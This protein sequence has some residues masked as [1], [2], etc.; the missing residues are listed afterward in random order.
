MKVKI[1]STWAWHE[2]GSQFEVDIKVKELGRKRDMWALHANSL[3]FPF[4]TMDACHMIAAVTREWKCPSQCPKYDRANVFLIDPRPWFFWFLGCPFVVAPAIPIVFTFFFIILALIC[5]IQDRNRSHA[6]M[7]LRRKEIKKSYF[8]DVTHA[9]FSLTLI[10]I[11][12]YLHAFMQIVHLLQVTMSAEWDISLFPFAVTHLFPPFDLSIWGLVWQ[13]YASARF[14]FAVCLLQNI[15]PDTFDDHSETKPILKTLTSGIVKRGSLLQVKAF[16][17]CLNRLFY[18][19]APRTR[20]WID[21]TEIVLPTT[22]LSL[23]TG[24]NPANFMQLG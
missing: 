14:I 15:R 22:K 12:H 16:R 18:S 21:P 1:K 24:Q 23:L 2:K 10:F 4:S 19:E 11:N 20:I 17:W 13:K 7:Q 8:V 6:G 9:S 5:L 3:S